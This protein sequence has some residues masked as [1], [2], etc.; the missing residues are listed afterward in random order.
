M[1]SISDEDFTLYIFVSD[2][3]FHIAINDER[4]CTFDHRIP[5]TELRAITIYYNI[6]I[7]RGIDHRSTFPSPQ[8]II[9]CQDDS[10]EFSQDLPI[11]PGPGHVII[12][13]AMP[14][15]GPGRFEFQLNQGCNTDKEAL[16]LSV[17][18]DEGVVVRNNRD[19]E[20]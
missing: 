9:Q 17:R 10:V 1:I 15:G 2:R 13:S 8:P 16:H 6:Q 3:A 14:Y 5:F 20:G 7:L 19:D 4:Y 11:I 18:F 12:L